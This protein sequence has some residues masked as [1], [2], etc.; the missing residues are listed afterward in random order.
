MSNGDNGRELRFKAALETE[1]FQRLVELANRLRDDQQA[2][3]I[4]VL[5]AFLA[6]NELVDSDDRSD[7]AS[8]AAR[9]WSL[10]M[11]QTI[12]QNLD[13]RSVSHFVELVLQFHVRASQAA[14]AHKRH[15]ENRALKAEVF[16]WC[17]AHMQEFRSMDSAAE[18][19]AGKLVPVKFRTAREWIGEWRKLRS[20]GTP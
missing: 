8:D 7:A 2:R 16:A 19:V 3:A 12:A 14:K 4:R 6:G 17:D 18:A 13:S 1:D 10:F 5:E 15:A 20:T 9:A 11:N